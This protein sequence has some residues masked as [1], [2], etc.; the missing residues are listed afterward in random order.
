MIKRLLFLTL[1]GLIISDSSLRGDHQETRIFV[2]CIIMHWFALSFTCRILDYFTLVRGKDRCRLCWPWSIRRQE[3][4]FPPSFWLQVIFHWF[5][6]RNIFKQFTLGP[7]ISGIPGH[8]QWCNHVDQLHPD[9][10]L[11]SHR[12]GHCGATLFTQKTS[13]CTEAN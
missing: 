4:R 3:L 10:L 2:R 6:L 11:V 13:K 1:E 5:I 8:E 12:C 9:Q 7:F